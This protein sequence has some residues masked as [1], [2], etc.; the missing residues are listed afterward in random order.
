MILL[1]LPFFLIELCL[2]FVTQYIEL[3]INYPTY[4]ISNVQPFWRDINI[5]FGVWHTAN[6][7]FVHKKSCFDVEYTSNSYGARDKERKMKAGDSKKRIVVLGDSFIEGFGVERTKRL[8][9][10]LEVKTGLEHLNF[11]T[12]GNFGT[13]Q[14]A[15][16]Y[17]TLA[18][19][20]DHDFVVI[21]MLPYNDFFDDS[22]EFGK[23]VY[24]NRYRPYYEGSYPNYKITYLVS[25]FN[26]KPYKNT[27][28]SYL[29][30]FTLSYN[31]ISYCISLF[32]Y[33]DNSN[34]KLKQNYSG[35]YDY[36]SEDLLRVRYSYERIVNLANK[37]GKR[38]LLFTIPVFSDF[39]RYKKNKKPAPLNIA[40]SK[41]SDEIGF[42]YFDLLP[43]MKKK[44]EIYRFFHSCDGHWNNFGHQLASEILFSKTHLYQNIK[45]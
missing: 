12:S 39:I 4:S 29:R 33:R 34:E 41:M 25:D 45:K 31:I 9:D 40:L 27:I 6:D 22:L 28:K 7:S 19:N 26:K 13:I 14:Q 18:I 21:G 42:E 43:S 10:L 2:Y 38:V 23:K 3:P 15:I 8:S 32:V 1:F 44:G 36:S 30:N 16:L 5:N 11:G 35:Y 20:F 17:E 24:K 37:S